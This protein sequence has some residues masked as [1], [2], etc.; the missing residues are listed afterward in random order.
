MVGAALIRLPHTVCIELRNRREELLPE[1]LELVATLKR[2]TS[3]RARSIVQHQH[4]LDA[5]GL[6]LMLGGIG[7][8][9]EQALL[10]PA[11]QNE[12]DRALRLEPRPGNRA[13]SLQHYHRAGA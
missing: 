11:E 2:L 8:G 9:A 13:G 12:A 10:F 7:A 4:R 5:V 1:P 6:R 3:D